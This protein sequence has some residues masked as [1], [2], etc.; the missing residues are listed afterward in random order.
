M[1]NL[2]ITTVSASQNQK[3]TT[4]NDADAALESALTE[5]LVV[6]LSAGNHTLST[7]EYTRNI[8]FAT[9]GNAIS[10]DLTFPAIERT[11]WV[12][13]GGS[14]VM[15][16]KRGSTTLTLAAGGYAFYY[17]DGTTNGIAKIDVTSGTSLA[18][19]NLTDAPANYTSA[20]YK[21]V[22][23]NA[24]ANGLEFVDMAYTIAFYQENVMT[25]AQI[26]Y[27]FIATVPFTLVAGLSGSYA[28]SEVASAGNVHFD[29]KKNGSDVGDIVFNVSST[30]SFTLG[31]DQSFAAGDVITIV[32]PATADLTLAGVGASIKCRLT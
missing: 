1:G 4:I 5:T 15:N 2:S 22:R 6:D 11:V 8:G 13:N 14:S 18:F 10:R 9:T 25:N 24:A 19:I 7:A 26:V 27:K 17:T 16:L 21:I 12:K 28:T 3:E 23:V 20:G 30:G 32:G 31:S 29:I